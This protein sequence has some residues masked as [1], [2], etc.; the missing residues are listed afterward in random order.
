V[1]NAPV[2][3]GR[4]RDVDMQAELDRWSWHAADRDRVFSRHVM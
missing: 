1:T 4:A 3:G 2:I